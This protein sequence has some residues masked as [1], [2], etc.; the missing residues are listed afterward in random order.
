MI[1]E[2]LRW[3]VSGD[4]VLVKPT[5]MNR[6]HGQIWVGLARRQPGILSRKG[7]RQRDCGYSIYRTKYDSPEVF[8][9][10]VTKSDFH[11]TKS[12]QKTQSPGFFPGWQC[13][14][15]GS[16]CPHMGMWWLLVE[17]SCKNQTAGFWF[18]QQHMLCWVYTIRYR[19]GWVINISVDTLSAICQTR[20]CQLMAAAF[21]GES[22]GKC[23]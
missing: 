5:L 20:C 16:I 21:I 10:H 7:K 19:D 22:T 8:D 6:R 3:I 15:G 1:G 12:W 11:V 14:S 9:F 4:C 17:L 18:H 2:E 13:M 23:N